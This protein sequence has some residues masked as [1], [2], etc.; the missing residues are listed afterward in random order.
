MVVP[1][2]LQNPLISTVS[3]AKELFKLE[4]RSEDVRGSFAVIPG[5]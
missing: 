5:I 2:Q 3:I 4:T 1:D